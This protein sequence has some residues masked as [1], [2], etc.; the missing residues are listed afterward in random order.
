MDP[1]TTGFHHFY[2]GVLSKFSINDACLPISSCYSAFH[3]GSVLGPI[4]FLLYTAKLID[5]I[6]ECGLM[7]HAYV[8]DTQVYVATQAN[9]TAMERLTDCIVNIRDWMASNRLK[10]NEDK[11][12]VIWLGKLTENTLT[13]P[14]ATVQFSTVVN[15]LGVQTDSQLSMSNHI[16]K[17]SRSCFFHLRQLRLIRQSLTPEAMN[18]LVQSFITTPKR[19]ILARN[20]VFWHILR[21]N[22]LRG[23]G[24]NELQEPPQKTEKNW[25]S[26]HFWCA[27]SRMRGIETPG[28]IVTNF[29]TGVG[30]HATT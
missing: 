29:C 16:A 11:T 19:H 2:T 24:C 12:Q 13:L 8:D 20:C 7:V 27:K 23:L 30:V 26:K 15:D 1:P 3:R 10:L 9:D 17:L 6:V 18:T 25:P 22:R 21:Q 28:R 4:L 14:N 5:I